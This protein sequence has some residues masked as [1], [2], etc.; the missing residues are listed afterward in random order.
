MSPTYVDKWNLLC[1]LLF[2]TIFISTA[3]EMYSVKSKFTY[4]FRNKVTS[5]VNDMPNSM[6]ACGFC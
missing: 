1:S 4:V 6:Q 3:R 5:C 2:I